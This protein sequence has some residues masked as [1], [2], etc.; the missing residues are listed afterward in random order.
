MRVAVLGGDGFIG[1]PTCLH[2]SSKGHEVAIVDNLSRRRIDTELGVQ[3]LTPMDSIQERLRIWQQQ[4]GAKLVYELC[5]I[6][7]ETEHLKELLDRLRP[8]AIIHL[9][10]QR[11][12]PYSMK[13]AWHKHYTVNNNVNSTHNLLNVLVDIDLDAHLVHLGT[14][15]VYGYNTAGSAIPEGYLKIQIPSEDGSVR[16]DEILHPAN[17]GSIYHMTKCLD[18]ILFGFYTKNDG[19]RITDLHQGIVWGTHTDQTRRHEQLINRFDYDGDYGTVL[20]RFLI[21]AAVNHPLTVHGTGGQTRAF[22]HIQD[23]VRCIELALE[24]PPNRG[25]RTKIFNQMT[26]VHRIRDLASLVHEM[27]GTPIAFVRNP[28][29]EASENELE[30]ENKQFL[31]LGLKPI[32]LKVGM[33]SE[34]VEVAKK[35]KHRIDMK[36]IPAQSAWTKEIG[37]NITSIIDIDN[38][39]RSA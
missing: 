9:A 16:E 23:S 25:D 35:Y 14:M 21:Q 15:G 4:T 6:A 26:E 7:T 34:L 11:A 36:R 13:S 29:Q 12:A 18:Q 20:N 37:Q 8:D 39:R 31:D 1:W 28:R 19:I 30:V 10:Q 22:I 27:S 33:L 3:S 38:R 2:L 5:D 24:N 32:T 17:P